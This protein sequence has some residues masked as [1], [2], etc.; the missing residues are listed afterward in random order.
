[1]VVD[2]IFAFFLV[3]LAEGKH[4]L[5]GIDQAVQQHGDD[6]DKEQFGGHSVSP[7]RQALA[8]LLCYAR[9]IPQNYI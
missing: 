8:S 7:G 5:G 3:V 6:G 1:M 4:F 2:H 9:I